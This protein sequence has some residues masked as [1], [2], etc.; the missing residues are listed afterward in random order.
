MA[1]QAVGT[2]QQAGSI[3]SSWSYKI[4]ILLSSVRALQI[5]TVRSFSFQND[6]SGLGIN[7]YIPTHLSVP[8]LKD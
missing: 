4:R 8:E 3:R 1:N 6:S 7:T 5:L 2:Q